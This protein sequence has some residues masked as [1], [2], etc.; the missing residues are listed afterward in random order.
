MDASNKV[1]AVFDETINVKELKRKLL[2]VVINNFDM[3]SEKYDS[4]LFRI[5][6]EE[7]INKI[8]FPVFNIDISDAMGAIAGKFNGEITSASQK[9]ELSSALA[10]AI[11]QIYDELYKRLDDKVTQFKTEM[12]EIS[13]KLEGNLLE[14]ISSEFNALLNECANKEKEIADYKEYIAILQKELS[15]I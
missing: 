4:S 10:K 15:E 3:G 6:V 5:M 9:T 14:N 13:K 2:N 7:T 12:A 11:S 8:E 1:E